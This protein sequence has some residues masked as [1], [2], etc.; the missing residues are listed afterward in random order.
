MESFEDSLQRGLPRVRAGEGGFLH[1]QLKGSL[2]NLSCWP[3]A[4]LP[5]FNLH[6]DF[7][8]NRHQLPNS[9]AVG[10]YF[11]SIM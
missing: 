2:E 1:S 3:M 5:I 11:C 9:Q 4:S 10:N 8:A 7:L 6:R